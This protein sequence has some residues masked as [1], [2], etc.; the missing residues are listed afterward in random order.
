[1]S[2][3]WKVVGI[4]VVALAACAGIAAFLAMRSTSDAVPR[5][6]RA[7][8][9]DARAQMSANHYRDAARSY[10]KGLAASPKVAIDPQVWCELADALGMAQ[11]GKLNGR[12][13]ELIQKAL[14]L[15]PNHPRALEMAGSAAY[16]AGDYRIALRY[17][18]RLLAQLDPA[19]SAYADL[20]SAIARTRSLI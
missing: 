12:P 4:V 14:A 20:S 8:V 6:G 10:E 1:M 9:L 5:D 16:E 2:D 18:E 13:S 11:G 17:W 3:R 19:S 7:W 15:N